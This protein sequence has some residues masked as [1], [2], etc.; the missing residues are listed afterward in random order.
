MLVLGS[1]N[2]ALASAQLII[3][4]RAAFLVSIASSVFRGAR[5]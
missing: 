4:A 5:L 3:P 2:A 1:A